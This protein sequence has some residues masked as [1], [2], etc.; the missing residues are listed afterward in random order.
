MPRS[1]ARAT[2][3]ERA[4]SRLAAALRQFAV[5]GRGGSATA[6]HW[7][8]ALTRLYGDDPMVLAPL[9]LQV[10]AIPAGRPYVVPPGW[11]W[12]HLFGQSVHVVAAGATTVGGGLGAAD[13]DSEGFVAA[14]TAAHQRVPVDPDAGALAQAAQL[15]RRRARQLGPAVTLTT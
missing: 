4:T 8:S 1:S 9:L 3:R 5:N 11:A 14:L 12:A 7:V 6:L 15:A 10:R 13:A 2:L